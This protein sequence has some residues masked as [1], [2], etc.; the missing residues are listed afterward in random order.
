MKLSKSLLV[1]LLFCTMVVCDCAKHHTSATK[2]L[3]FVSILPQQ[4][5][6]Q[7]IAGDLVDVAVMVEPGASPHA[8]EPKPFQMTQLSHAQAYFSIGIEFENVWLPRFAS[9]APHMHIIHTDTLITKIAGHDEC[10][11]QHDQSIHDADEHEGL[12]PHI[13]LSPQLVQQQAQTICRGLIQMD[14]AH[15][16]I[17]TT[18]CA[19]FLKE[20][21]AVQDTL[22]TLLKPGTTFMVFHPAWAYFA[23][24]FGLNQLSVEINGQEPSPRE[25]SNILKQAQQQHIT[26]IFVQPQF[27][28]Q[29]AGVIAHQLKGRVVVA[30]DLA[31]NWS[32]NLISV[33]K[34][35]A[36]Q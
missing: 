17:Y 30:N 20:I 19:L 35:I 12:D 34:A 8:Y 23:R 1:L 36:A 14:S 6:V 21:A 27:S 10:N 2:P 13:W 31:A 11:E 18:N 3:V 28:Q 26:T 22:H 24:E 9:L 5:F 7:K 33:A 15:A 32:Q 4:Y 25:L 16:Q 29:S